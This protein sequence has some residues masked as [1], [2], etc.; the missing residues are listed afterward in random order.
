MDIF[1]NICI[2]SN[3]QILLDLTL[4]IICQFPSNW[5]TSSDDASVRDNAIDGGLKT[6]IIKNRGVGIGTA[7]RT[8]TK[9]P[10]KGDGSGAECTV[11]INNDS[12]IGS[13]VVSNQGKVILLVM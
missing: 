1:G 6:V 12:K 11:V 5:E 3:H 2:L 7:N 8:Y 10:I 4:Q 9:V 13:V